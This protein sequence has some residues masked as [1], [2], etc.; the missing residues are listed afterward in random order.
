MLWCQKGPLGEPKE[1]NYPGEDGEKYHRD[2]EPRHNEEIE[3]A[4]LEHRPHQL[5]HAR[6][7]VVGIESQDE[8]DEADES[9]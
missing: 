2:V 3:N 7:A 5:C 6:L 9:N 8:D 1:L 4:V